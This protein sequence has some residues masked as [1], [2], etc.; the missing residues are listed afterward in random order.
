MRWS[1]RRSSTGTR[2]TSRPTGAESSTPGSRSTSRRAGTRW[3]C[4]RR[5]PRRRGPGLR[6]RPRRAVRHHLR[7]RRH[8]HGHGTPR[9]LLAAWNTFVLDEHARRP[10]PGMAVLYERLRATH[11]GCPVIYVST[12]AWNVA[13]TL[14]RF[15]TRNFYPPGPLLLTD[16]GPTHDRWFRSGRLHKEQSLGRI[17]AEFPQLKWLLVGDDGQHDEELYGD[18]LRNHPD[19]VAAVAIRQLSSS[20]AVFAGGRS[21]GEEHERTTRVP[22]LYAPDGAGLWDQLVAK[23]L[24]E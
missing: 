16:W 13:P 6:H 19:N 5:A 9:P 10:V 15:L 22:W 20:E 1:S 4:E 17:A 24:V 18:F 3:C 7:H 23:G 12:G 21:R 8:R 14:S 11:L 2:T